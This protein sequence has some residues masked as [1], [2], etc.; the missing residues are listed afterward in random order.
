ML[1]CFFRV[2][3]CRFFDETFVYH[4]L[5]I[6]TPRLDIDKICSKHIIRA[7][8]PKGRVGALNISQS[9]SL[10]FSAH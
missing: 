2:S 10:Q 3:N 5:T 4:Y 8:I 6:A 1:G 9:K 7:P